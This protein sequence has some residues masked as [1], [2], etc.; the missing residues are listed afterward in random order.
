MVPGQHEP[1]LRTLVLALV[2]P[3]ALGACGDEGALDSTTPTPS[4]SVSAP[5]ST[6]APSLPLA[7]TP[8][9][10]A[11]ATSSTS[12]S[13]TSAESSS[14]IFDL[15]VLTLGV[16][17]ELSGRFEVI[18]TQQTRVTSAPGRYWVLPDGNVYTRFDLDTDLI[19]DEMAALA[20][21]VAVASPALAGTGLLVQMED[22]YRGAEF[23][24]GITDVVRWFD[25][26]IPSLEMLEQ[27]S[28]ILGAG[29]SPGGSVS[30]DCR[31]SLAAYET[32]ARAW[33]RHLDPDIL[34]G[35][36]WQFP[37]AD[38]DAALSAHVPGAEACGEPMVEQ[39]GEAAP[40]IE[41]RVSAR[42]NGTM[43][44]VMADDGLYTDHEP[45]PVFTVLMQPDDAVG[46]IPEP[47]D[48]ESLLSLTSTYLV[49]VGGCGELPWAH[50]EFAGGD[51]W[52]DPAEEPLVG[53]T[54]LADRLVCA[55]EVPDG[56]SP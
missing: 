28:V 6:L 11:T 26:R 40:E 23:Q 25:L 15:S 9:T 55:S 42:G 39:P 32:A 7:T 47:R 14:E 4:P 46:P 49:A 34:P 19:A 43:I 17:D 27:A 52:A 22:H 33:V 20:E 38:Y 51:T 50:T 53:V 13:T 5:T 12:T 35:T 18:P 1:V 16:D 10:A 3:L 36:I 48:P 54:F 56:I 44:E 29:V 24:V 30:E 41:F 37:V 2:L 21:E 31:R 45:A 8:S